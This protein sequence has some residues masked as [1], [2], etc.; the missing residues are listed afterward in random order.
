MNKTC[1][2]LLVLLSAIALNISTMYYVIYKTPEDFIERNNILVPRMIIK[3]HSEFSIMK[4]YIDGL[5]SISVGSNNIEING[6]YQLKHSISS[7]YM[8][9]YMNLVEHELLYVDEDLL[10]IIHKKYIKF[11]DIRKNNKV[12]KKIS[13]SFTHKL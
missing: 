13:L 12:D 1:L 2:L 10:V 7:I 5:L 9:K 11:I 4:F 8:G 3:D 6:V